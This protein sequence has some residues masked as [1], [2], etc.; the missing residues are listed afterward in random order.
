MKNLLIVTICINLLFAC[1]DSTNNSI[2][3]LESASSPNL[4]NTPLIRSEAVSS[5][6][7]AS[8]IKIKIAEKVATGIELSEMDNGKHGLSSED[9]YASNT[10]QRIQVS[11]GEI[12]LYFKSTFDE[13]DDKTV[14]ITPQMKGKRALTWNCL[15]G[16]LPQKYRPTACRK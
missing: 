15:G 7:E 1:E 5:L 11:D 14:I 13:L 9:D 12:T 4:D 16:S 3:N 2:S 8:R 10:V 6:T